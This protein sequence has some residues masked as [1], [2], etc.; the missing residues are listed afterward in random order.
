MILALENGNLDNVGEL[1]NTFEDAMNATRQHL[2]A[3]HAIIVLF[4]DGTPGLM[5]C[6][7]RGFVRLSQA[8]QSSDIHTLAE[9]SCKGG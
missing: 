6:N 7:W 1:I 3:E 9:E 5:Q 2:T 4:H 8:V